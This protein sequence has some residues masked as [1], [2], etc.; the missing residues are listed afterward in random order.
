LEYFY[1]FL[2]SGFDINDEQSLTIG[3]ELIII[4]KNYS[5]IRVYAPD[6]SEIPGWFYLSKKQIEK[7]FGKR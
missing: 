3:D 6:K 1:N 4:K 5:S 2:L 7:L